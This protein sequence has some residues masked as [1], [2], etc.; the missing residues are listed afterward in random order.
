[1]PDSQTQTL[2]P[3]PAGP[4]SGRGRAWGVV[5][6]LAALVF[7]A[8]GTHRLRTGHADPY[9]R[10]FATMGTY[11]RLTFYAPAARAAPAAD[12]VVA[13]LAALERCINRFAPESELSRL[14][15][16]AAETP[17]ACSDELWAILGAARRAWE[18]TGGAFDVTVGPLMR[19]WGFHRERQGYPTDAEI[20]A[21]LELV[22]LGKLHFD[23]ARHTVR[24][25]RPGMELDFG[26]LAKGY[27][28][29]LA[30]PIAREHGVRQ[31]LIDLG[32]NVFCLDEPPP[33]RTAYTLGVRD[34]AAPDRLL[35]TLSLRGQAIATSG[36]Y[37][38]WQT[39]DGRRVT[40]IMDPRTGRPVAGVAGVSVVTPRGVD[41]DVLSTAVF[42]AGPALAEETARRLAHTWILVVS[43][44][45]GREAAPPREFGRLPDAR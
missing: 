32:G 27:A 5:A 14:N 28:L 20:A 3:V 8:W 34:P 11:G 35:R 10:E 42:V 21:A 9:V 23:D 4:A 29:D 31:G 39:L 22:G 2:A 7:A 15:R 44:D 13:R 40:H 17:F 43:G 16:T 18:E 33:G 45:G 41:S 1:M 19:L 30:A 36:D 6:A 38:Q 37:E 24:F 12:A 25:A 26:G